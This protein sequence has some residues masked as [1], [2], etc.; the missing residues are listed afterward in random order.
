MSRTDQGKLLGVVL[1]T[2]A[3]LWL[4]YPSYR[5]YTMTP[6]QRQAKEPA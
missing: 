4:L 3:S 2:L 5:F 6:V 1:V